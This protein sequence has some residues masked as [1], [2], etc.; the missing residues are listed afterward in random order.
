MSFHLEIPSVPDC[1]NPA[2][3]RH[4]LWQQR[5]LL[6]RLVYVQMNNPG[7]GLRFDDDGRLAVHHDDVT[8]FCD[9]DMGL[10]AVAGTGSGGTGELT[11]TM[12][13]AMA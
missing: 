7:C 9:D 1:S 13:A 11:T 4:F 10:Y 12:I 5:E 3:V 8:I 2:A 6:I